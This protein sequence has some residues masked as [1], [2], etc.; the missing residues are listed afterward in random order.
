MKDLKYGLDIQYFAE[1]E[2]EGVGAQEP[3]D[4]SEKASEI[5]YSKIE[6]IINKRSSS[7]ADSVLKGYL[8]QLGLT[9]EELEQAAT[10]YKERKAQEAKDAKEAQE[11]MKLENQRLKEEILNSKIDTQ[12]STLAGQEGVATDKIPFL[13]KLIDRKVLVNDKGEIVEDKAKEELSK[14]IKAF[15]DFKGTNSSGNVGFQQIGSSGSDNNPN[16]LDD[17]LDSIF[18]IKK[19]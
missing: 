15:P 6:E 5:D 17:K 19:K 3:K 18:G 16:S 4:K 7:N 14:V 2:G 11:N 13:L 9:G 8:K 10:S 1:G 12:V